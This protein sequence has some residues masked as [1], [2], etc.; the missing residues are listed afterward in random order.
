MEAFC[1]HF[2][3]VGIWSTMTGDCIM[4]CSGHEDLLRSGCFFPNGELQ[5][6]AS[7]DSTTR[8]RSTR[9][10]MWGTSKGLCLWTLVGHEHYVNTA[11]FFHDV[12]SVLT[13]SQDWTVKLSI[14]TTGQCMQTFQ[15]I[16]CQHIQN[17]G[18]QHGV[19]SL[20]LN[21]YADAVVSAVLALL[22]VVFF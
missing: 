7:L 6:I 20:T 18:C 9:S 13:A 22:R 11:I 14:L 10:K 19:W 12:K 21:G 5:F 15:S 8:I 4:T 16:G 3:M 2:Q 1:S 17:L